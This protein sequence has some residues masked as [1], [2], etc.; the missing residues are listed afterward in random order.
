MMADITITCGFGSING[1]EFRDD[2]KKK[3]A[4]LLKGGHMGDL[5]EIRRDGK[6]RWEVHSRSKHKKCPVHNHS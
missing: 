4:D 1:L 3:G 6:V 5:K 2:I